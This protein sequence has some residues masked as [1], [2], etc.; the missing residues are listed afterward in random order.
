MFTERGYRAPLCAIA[1]EAGVGQGVLYRHFPTRLDLAFAAFEE[2]FVE[3]E[4]IAAEPDAEAF[5][6]LWSRLVELTVVES[7]FI[8]MIVDARRTLPEQDLDGRVRRLVEATM[9]M[10]Q[11]AGAVRADLSTSD[12]L[13][14]IRMVYGVVVLTIDPESVADAVRHSLALVAIEPR[15]AD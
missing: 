10:A 1:R 11:A 7:A 15:R 14:I 13:L 3:L 6:R 5:G 9:P 8:E 12:L 4:A 2:R